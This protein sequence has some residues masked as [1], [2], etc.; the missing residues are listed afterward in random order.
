MPGSG[1]ADFKQMKMLLLM[2]SPSPRGP[3]LELRSRGPTAPKNLS[4]T[5]GIPGSFQRNALQQ[6]E[7]TQKKMFLWGK[8][9]STKPSLLQHS[10]LILW[11]IDVQSFVGEYK[12][13]ALSCFQDKT[14]QEWISHSFKTS[15][16]NLD[17]NFWVHPI[18]LSSSESW[19]KNSLLIS[20]KKSN[21]VITLKG[22]QLQRKSVV[23]G[24][25]MQ[26]SCDPAHSGT[27][28][29]FCLTSKET[30]QAL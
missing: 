19:K 16:K 14:I 5:A 1:Q 12:E 7:N 3:Q 13:P 18:L 4:H 6:R 23:I 15:K 11:D 9:W 21:V 24:S 29:C 25:F 17:S 26:T 10:Y 22:V 27:E 8:E 20:A 30:R 2:A 28:N